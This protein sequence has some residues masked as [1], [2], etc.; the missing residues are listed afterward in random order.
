MLVQSLARLRARQ[1]LRETIQNRASMFLNLSSLVNIFYQD[2][3]FQLLMHWLV[4]GC[5]ACVVM[6][7]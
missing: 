6:L 4:L 2:I 5:S 1:V 3:R 7:G